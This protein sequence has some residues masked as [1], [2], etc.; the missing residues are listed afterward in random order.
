[1]HK[2][3]LDKEVRQRIESCHLIYD[4]VPAGWG[5]GVF[6]GNGLLGVMAYQHGETFSGIRF[7]IGRADLNDHR[8]L[9]MSEESR[10]HE[11]GIVYRKCRLPVGAFDLETGDTVTKARTCMELYKA[12]IWGELITEKGKLSWQCYVPREP[13]VIIFKMEE[14]GE[15]REEFRFSPHPSESPRMK[16][17]P[18]ADYQSNPF[19]SIKHRDGITFCIQAMIAGGSY[20]TAWTCHIEKGRKYWIVSVGY[21]LEKE[22]SVTEAYGNLKKAM[23]EGM[24]TIRRRHEQWWADYYHKSLIAIPDKELEKFYWIQMYKI[25]SAS[26]PDGPVIDTCGPWLKNDTGWPAVWWNLNVQLTY[27]ICYT[28]NHIQLTESMTRNIDRHMDALRDNTPIEYREDSLFLGNP[29][30]QDMRCA[31]LYASVKNVGTGQMEISM[32]LN[33]LPWICHNYWMY[34]R[35]KMDD[36]LLREKL[37]PLMKGT[38]QLYLHLLYQGKDGL[39]HL[40]KMFSAEYGAAEDTNQDLALLL[41]GCKTLLWIC[42]RL[43]LND[44]MIPRWQD[45]IEKLVPFPQD[46]TGLLIGKGIPLTKSHR[47]FSHLMAIFPLH[48]INMEDESSRE[49]AKRSVNHWIG[50]DELLTGYSY[51]TAAL[52]MECIQEGTKALNYIRVFLKQAHSN[53]MYTEVGELQWPTLETPLTVGKCLHDMLLQSWGDKIRIFP[54]V[55]DEWKDIEFRNL[56]AEGAFEVSASMKEGRTA[57]INI[58]SLAGEPCRIVTD[59]DVLQ[60]KIFPG[61]RMI[62]EEDG[63]YYVDIRKGEEVTLEKRTD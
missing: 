60:A 20:A 63:S 25:A 41:W 50:L 16:H 62:R 14:E 23:A 40:P 28:S 7:E 30:N 48:L 59:M 56:L 8:E 37:F 12:R 43:K 9:H 18:E 22:E 49:L 34:Y 57:Y 52:M 55:P 5:E 27:W 4:H 47:H 3:D 39:Y 44:E 29:T 36:D 32:E 38:F 61:R 45:V 15:E 21:S 10:I 54:A 24:E 51:T 35:C 19:P 53:T 11:E 17:V 42:K 6:A 33:C 46:E 13:H 58:K 2:R 1:M 31:R 26:R